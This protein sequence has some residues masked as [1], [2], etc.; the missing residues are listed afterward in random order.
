M[1]L[2]IY[3]QY[4]ISCAILAAANLGIADVIDDQPQSIEAIAQALSADPGCLLRLLRALASVGVFREQGD[5]QFVHTPRSSALR[6][7]HPANES[8]LIRMFGIKSVREAMAEYES[9]IRTG[10]PAF[11]FVHGVPNPFDLLASR[12]EELAAYHEGMSLDG[13][14]LSQILEQCDFRSLRRM[15]DVGGGRGRLLARILSRYRDM[16]GV[17]FDLPGVV[18]GHVLAE[19]G[20]LERCEVQSGDLRAAVPAAADGYLLKNILHGLPDEECLALLQRIRACAAPRARI[21]VIENVMASRNQL[22]FARLFDLFLLL[23]GGRTRVRSE[24]EFRELFARSGFECTQVRLILQRQCV[25][26]GR[27]N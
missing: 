19:Y 16:R 8:A 1:I 10:R 26:E 24:P 21:F 23:G 9:A 22:D 14:L 5:R 3:L 15:V 20:V 2:E 7:A 18:A 25:V 17:L 13:E 6:R 11:E 12:P 4:W 27:L